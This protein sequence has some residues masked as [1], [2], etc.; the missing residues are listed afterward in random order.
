MFRQYILTV[1][2]LVAMG[3]FVYAEPFK[4]FGFSMGMSLEEVKSLEGIEIVM[5]DSV[6][7]RQSIKF[8][9]TTTTPKEFSHF[10]NFWAFCTPEHGLYQLRAWSDNMDVGTGG[11][12]ILKA[13][14][15]IRKKISERYDSGNYGTRNY[16]EGNSWEPPED[17]TKRFMKYNGKGFISEWQDIPRGKKRFKDDVYNVKLS[18]PISVLG[19]G[20]IYLVIE[21][22]N[23]ND[24]FNKM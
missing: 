23:A 9:K 15:A 6:G 2:V 5:I 18:I 19:E 7:Y 11:E 24:A 10:V 8:R 3:S 16:V 17:W 4:P 21:F 1:C 14:Y 13:Y 12:K 20:T 22:W